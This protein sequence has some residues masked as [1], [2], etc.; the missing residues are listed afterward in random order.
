MF[1]YAFSFVFWAIYLR[2]CQTVNVLTFFFKPQRKRPGNIVYQVSSFPP[3]S[4]PAY[5][6][7]YS[8]LYSWQ[9]CRL[10]IF[11]ATDR[12]QVQVL[13]NWM[14]RRD[15]NQQGGSDWGMKNTYC[16]LY[17]WDTRW[18]SW[19]RRCATSWKAAVSISGGVIG[20]FH[21]HNPSSRTM[22]PLWPW[23]RLSL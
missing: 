11:D 9:I 20:F 12:T 18:R 3:K 14:L 19:L 21:W 16:I 15:L 1:V 23:G 22:A 6:S 2:I 13:E 5:H 17:K 10:F 4:C 7:L 8:K